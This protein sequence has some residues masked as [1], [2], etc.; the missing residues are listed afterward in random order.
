M[1]SLLG[2]GRNAGNDDEVI[3]S[4]YA[5]HLRAE[6]TAP[7]WFAATRG[8]AGATF[9]RCKEVWQ[10]GSTVADDKIVTSG[11]CGFNWS[12][13]ALKLR[14]LKATLVLCDLGPHFKW[15]S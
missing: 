7:N 3:R 15:R 12:F 2:A 13:I 8:T 1:D 11:M 5:K 10:G 6:M 14:R 4:F 9:F